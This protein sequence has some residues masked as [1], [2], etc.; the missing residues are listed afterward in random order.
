M[1]LRPR[2]RYPGQTTT[3]PA[4]PHGKARD[5]AMS[6]DGTGTPLQEDLVNDI[7]G[8]QQALLAAAGITPS[9]VPDTAVVSQYLDAIQY[10]ITSRTDSLDAK[11]YGVF[12]PLSYGAEG[13]S[14][15]DDTSE[16][17]ACFAAAY[18]AIDGGEVTV[19]LGGLTYRVTGALTC[20]PHV[21]VRNGKIVLDASSPPSAF[22]VW[23]TAST[24][25]TPAVWSGVTLEFADQNTLM[26][27]NP[28]GAVFAEFADCVLDCTTGG[29]AEGLFSCAAAGSRFAFRNCRGLLQAAGYGFTTTAACE[30]VID[31]GS[32][33]SPVGFSDFMVTGSAGTQKISGATFDMT[34]T[35]GGGAVAINIGGQR[36]IATGC[37]FLDN[38]QGNTAFKSTLSGNTAKLTESG[39]YFSHTTGAGLTVVPYDFTNYLELGSTVDGVPHINT[40]TSSATPT[41]PADARTYSLRSTRASTD[42]PTVTFEEALYAGQVLHFL[43]GNDHTDAWV[44]P[45]V[46]SGVQYDDS[47]SALDSLLANSTAFF[48]A[49]LVA[50]RYEGSLLWVVERMNKVVL[51]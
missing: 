42:P 13:D 17:Q 50:H 46:L 45:I 39:N 34:A 27:S 33:V 28:S 10:L 31:G 1:A 51:V 21:N 35:T 36:V 20:Y 14:A 15:E 4:Y 47:D 6:G 22:L 44:G 49:T 30:L 40:A 26:V 37:L 18:A 48:T 23:S 25:A 5:V 8:L 2:G 16:L 9:E 32:Y 43:L 41:V 24:E 11:T 29:G 3:D 7:F 19:D 12:S 38:N